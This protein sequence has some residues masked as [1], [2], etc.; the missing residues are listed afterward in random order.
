[1]NNTN[2]HAL[3][4]K[5]KSYRKEGEDWKHEYKCRIKNKLEFGET[6]VS[7]AVLFAHVCD[8][9]RR[10]TTKKLRSFL[11]YCFIQFGVFF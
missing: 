4:Q 6:F 10:S 5:F 9:G 8:G 11:L 3:E 1:M 7:E 2:T